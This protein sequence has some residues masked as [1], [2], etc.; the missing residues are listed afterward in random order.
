[1]LAETYRQRLY[2]GRIERTQD[3]V[4]SIIPGDERAAFDLRISIK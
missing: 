3:Y 1:M 4:V 2:A